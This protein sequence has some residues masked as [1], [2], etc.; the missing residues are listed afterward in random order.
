MT[1]PRTEDMLD[2]T[3]YPSVR[4]HQRTEALEIITG[5]EGKNQ[6]DVLDPQGDVIAYGTETTG[7]FQRILLGSNRLESIDVLSASGQKIASLKERWG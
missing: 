5:I 4:I 7:G 2:L 3:Q 6:Y 1:G